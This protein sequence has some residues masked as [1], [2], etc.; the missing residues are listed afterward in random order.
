MPVYTHGGD[1]VAAQR[2]YGGAVLDFSANL[3][4][5]GMPEEVRAA[6]ARAA[7]SAVNYPDPLC[8]ALREGI[9]Q[10]DGVSPE[11]I[12]C[13]NGAADL[14]F[15]MAFSLRPRQAL[16]TAPTFSEYEAALTA[17]GC[18]VCHH[19]L[20]EEQ[21]FDL[22]G[23]VLEELTE[24]LDLCVLCT[25][26]NPTGRTI[27]PSLMRQ[28]LDRCAERGIV[29]AVDECFLD[30][31]EE[32]SGLASLVGA[33]PNLILVRAFTKSYAIPGLRLGY[34]ITG[35]ACLAEG[36]Y[37]CG[38]PWPVSSPAQAAG[39]AALNCPDWPGRARAVI[40]PERVFLEEGLRALGLTVWSGKANYL[41]FRAGGRADLREQLLKRGILIRSCANYPGLGPDYYR[42]AVRLHE[43]NQRL[44]NAMRGVLL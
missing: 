5:L 11:Q 12:I 37:R 7:A 27:D 4:P 36:L 18:Q 13:G 33:Y 3:N 21:S 28:I 2:E 10:R 39:Q 29:L 31:T 20:Q 41:L 8:R 42:I 38:Q 35:D 14:L 25:P 22:T 30:L 6:A 23:A 34:V 26:N 44:M 19:R 16:V 1:V 43:E 40:G 17:A 15:R 32:G 24:D 9:A